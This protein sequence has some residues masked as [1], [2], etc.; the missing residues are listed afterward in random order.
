MY[1]VTITSTYRPT[2]EDEQT[3]TASYPYAVIWKARAFMLRAVQR[4]EK[5][6]DALEVIIV[7]R[8]GDEPL[9]ERNVALPSQVFDVDES[10]PELAYPFD[11]SY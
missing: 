3:Y 8:R 5:D 2:G 11:S 9:E 4:A 6:T 7:L 1:T 10:A